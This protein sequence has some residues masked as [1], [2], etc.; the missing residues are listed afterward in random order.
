[1]KISIINTFVITFFATA[2]CFGQSTP[3][4]EN[5][6]RKNIEVGNQ[7]WTT[8]NLNVSHFRNGDVIPEAKT[9]KEWLDCYSISSPAWCYYDNDPKNGEKHG[10]LYN[11]FAVND[12]RGLAPKGWHIPTDNEWQEVI[13]SYGGMNSA[14]EKLKK[15]EG[16]AGIPSGARDFK[17]GTFNHFGN[18]T[19]WWSASKND[20]WNAWYHAIH[21]G[22]KQTARDNGG[23]NAGHSVRLVKDS[24]E[25]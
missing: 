6:S 18:I 7:I 12:S 14:F 24:Q 10:K 1:M 5:A 4:V 15:T 2:T 8:E 23:M 19:F 11:W 9:I 3:G 13:T 22:Y 16:F 17:S 20:K 21:F 25:K